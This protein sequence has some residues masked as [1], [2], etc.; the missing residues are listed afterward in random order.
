MNRIATRDN[1]N[2]IMEF[3]RVI[4]VHEDGSVT[5]EANVWAPEVNEAAGQLDVGGM[6]G[7]VWQ[8]LNGYSGQQS[9]AGPVMHAS[10]YIGGR[11]ADDIL[12]TPGVYAAVVVADLDNATEDETP[13]AGWAV[14]KLVVVPADFPVK[15]LTTE[16]DK[17]AAG[18]LVTCGNCGR[19]WDD[20]IVTGWTPAPSARCPFEYFH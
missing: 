10:E 1:L 4:R 12:S 5:D 2:D 11:L 9:Y 8:L 13:E 20:S 14:A 17:A 7:Q 19:S 18:D 6:S 16:A 3:D 15:V